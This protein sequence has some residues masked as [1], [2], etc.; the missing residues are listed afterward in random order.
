MQAIQAMVAR[1]RPQHTLDIGTGTGLLAA[2]V[3][4][5]H[6]AAAA[7][8]SG[9]AMAGK[10]RV[11]A[12]EL[13]PPMARGAAHQI[14]HVRQIRCAQSLTSI[15]PEPDGNLTGIRPELDWDLTGT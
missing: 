14:R 12:V 15:R 9:A 8:S 7:A 5:A 2:L 4:R 1:H 6:V 10:P 13:F 3:C 11:T